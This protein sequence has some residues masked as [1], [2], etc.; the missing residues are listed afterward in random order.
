[1]FL[2]FGDPKSAHF[3]A[4]KQFVPL[5]LCTADDQYLIALQITQIGLCICIFPLFA[6]NPKSNA[7]KL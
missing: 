1:M 6:C 7:L 4:K 5:L 3:K 2:P